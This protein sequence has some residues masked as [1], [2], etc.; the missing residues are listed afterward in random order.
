MMIPPL[1]AAALVIAPAAPGSAQDSGSVTMTVMGALTATLDGDA[2]E[3]VTISGEMRGETGASANWQRIEISVPTFGDTLGAMAGQL[4][5]EER[6]QVQALD[7]LMGQ[8]TERAMGGFQS[9][10]LTISGHDPASPNI[11]TDQVLALDVHLN[12]ADIAPGTTMDA[13]ITYVVDG[14][15]GFI[16]RLF[17]T[18][19][20][21][22]TQA[23][24]T[25]DRL[26]LTPGGGHAEGSFSAELCK[27]EGANLISGP[28]LSDCIHVEGRFDTALV[29]EEPYRN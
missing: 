18:S 26:D 13:D 20:D 3:W 17:Y 5:E 22:D 25:F 28:D 16:P 12:S 24:V 15:G 23:S 11:L 10:N 4:S 7:Q 14:S 6:A 19:S 9:I 1:F 21:T 27:M 29:E 8:V 2:R